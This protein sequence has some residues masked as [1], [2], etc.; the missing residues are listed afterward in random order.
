MDRGGLVDK[1][2]Q[3]PD[4]RVRM[5]HLLGGGRGIK[6]VGAVLRVWR[7]GWGRELLHVLLRQENSGRRMGRSQTA[8]RCVMGHAVKA[9]AQVNVGRD[10]TRPPN[11]RAN[12]RLLV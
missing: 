10:R 7:D 12:S 3:R 1:P 8:K 9:Q 4:Q 6:R 11:K 5:F 2:N